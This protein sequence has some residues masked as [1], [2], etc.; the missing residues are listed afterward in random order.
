MPSF[1]EELRRL[2]RARGVTMQQLALRAGVAERSLRNWE[3]NQH[4]PGAA[5]L[6]LLLQALSVNEEELARLLDR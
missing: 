6:S 3:Q 4:E 5:E 2:R 1:G